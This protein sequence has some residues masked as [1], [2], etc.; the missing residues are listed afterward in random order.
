MNQRT[1]PLL[2]ALDAEKLLGALGTCS[3]DRP[4]QVINGEFKFTWPQRPLKEC[5]AALKLTYEYEETEG[6]F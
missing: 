1:Y 3:G 5:L 4:E 6:V 2:T